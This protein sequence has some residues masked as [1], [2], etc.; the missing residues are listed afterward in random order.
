MDDMPYKHTT[1]LGDD[2]DE[3][4]R[5]MGFEGEL[6]TQCSDDM[7]SPNASGD[8]E[9]VTNKSKLSSTMTLEEQLSQRRREATAAGKGH[10]A[11]HINNLMRPNIKHLIAI[12]YLA[13]LQLRCPIMLADLH[14][15][16]HE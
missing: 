5:A 2:M 11:M 16:E 14:R 4:L 10:T 12:C 13:C 3:H 8:E 1:E 6:S 9:N 15:Y 7:I